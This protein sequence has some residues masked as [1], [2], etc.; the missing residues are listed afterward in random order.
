MQEG[1]AQGLQEGEARGIE[2]GRSEGLQEGKAQGEYDKAVS[3][4][5][6]LLGRGLSEEDIAQI[7]GLA[8]EQVRKIKT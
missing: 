4:A 5:R 7:T 6:T 3:I 2:K 8:I 1:K